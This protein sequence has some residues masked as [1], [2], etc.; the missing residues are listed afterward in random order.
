MSSLVRGLQ[1]LEPRLGPVMTTPS[2]VDIKAFFD[3]AMVHFGDGG[4][5]A[6]ESDLDALVPAPTLALYRSL[7]ADPTPLQQAPP[8]ALSPWAVEALCRTPLTSTPPAP[9][10]A[11]A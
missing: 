4:K 10:A 5:E 9:A 11:P 8:Q 3:P 6:A 2:A 1:A 7:L